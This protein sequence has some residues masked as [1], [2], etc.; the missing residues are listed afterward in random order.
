MD[1]PIAISALKEIN[2]L[3]VSWGKDQIKTQYGVEACDAR[4]DLVL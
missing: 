2:Q 3:M 4:R 1:N